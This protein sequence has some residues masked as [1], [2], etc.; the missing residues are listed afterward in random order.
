MTLD[1]SRK[2]GV[3]MTTS[4]EDEIYRCIMRGVA[5]LVGIVFVLVSA[6]VYVPQLREATSS[7]PFFLASVVL[8]VISLLLLISNGFVRSHGFQR[9]V[10]LCVVISITC[11]VIVGAH[12]VNSKL[13]VLGALVLASIILAGAATFGKRHKGDLTK[14]LF[15]AFIGLLTLLIAGVLNVA[16]LKSSIVETGLSALGIVLFVCI[17]A[18]DANVYSKRPELC[19][20]NCCEE[21]TFSMFINF[22]NIVMDLM[23]LMN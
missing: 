21:G 17:A 11:L 19:R 12:T 8:T 7:R 10:Q 2:D 15:P 13:T 3:F 22:S 5:I 14:L 4:R 18:M 23:N 20:Y 16:L 6:C 1:R 9:A